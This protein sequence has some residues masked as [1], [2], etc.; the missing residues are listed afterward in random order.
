MCLDQILTWLEQFDIQ[1][2][3]NLRIVGR[4]VEHDLWA[5]LDAGDVDWHQI[6]ADLCPLHRAGA[7]GGDVEH[8]SPQPADG[9]VDHVAIFSA[10]QDRGCSG[11]PRF[12]ASV[13]PVAAL[14]LEWAA[15]AG[16]LIAHL[17]EQAFDWLVLHGRQ[18]GS[19]FIPRIMVA[20]AKVTN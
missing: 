13:E 3:L 16:Q 20:P 1:D 9:D 12:L 11:I 15:G 6:L 14:D 17:F 8:F 18:S 2:L 4:D 19:K 5:F 10:G 7:G